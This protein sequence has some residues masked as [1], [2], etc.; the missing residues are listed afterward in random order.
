VGSH[1]GRVCGAALLP[2]RTKPLSS[3]HPHAPRSVPPCLLL[4]MVEHNGLLCR[5]R[6]DAIVARIGNHVELLDGNVH[7]CPQRSTPH[8]TITARPQWGFG[9]IHG[10][11]TLIQCAGLGPRRVVPSTCRARCTATTEVWSLISGLRNTLHSP[12]PLH[13]LPPQTR[14]AFSD[15]QPRSTDDYSRIILRELL[16]HTRTHKACPHTHRPLA[17][18][19]WDFS[20]ENHC[21]SV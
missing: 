21:E 9:A 8:D 6:E 15:R 7:V 5:P 10:H 19:V 14:V 18:L 11:P 20:N 3:P 4:N 1:W 16:P 2:T 13:P 17:V 12:P